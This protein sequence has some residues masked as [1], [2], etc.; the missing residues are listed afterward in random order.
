MDRGKGLGDR[1]KGQIIKNTYMG[2]SFC[3]E[4]GKGWANNSF[5]IEKRND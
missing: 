2:V 1:F 5:I 4:E 3:K